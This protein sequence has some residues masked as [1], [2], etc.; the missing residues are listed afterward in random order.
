MSFYSRGS[1]FESHHWLSLWT[2]LICAVR[3]KTLWQDYTGCSFTFLTVVSVEV[4]RHQFIVGELVTDQ[5]IECCT[6]TSLTYLTWL[7]C[8]TS[9]EVAHHRA[10]RFPLQPLWLT[11]TCAHL[12]AWFAGVCCKVKTPS[13]GSARRVS[14]LS[15][16]NNNSDNHNNNNNN[17]NNNKYNNNSN[18][19]KSNNNNNNHNNNYN[20]VI[21]IIVMIVI[22]IGWSK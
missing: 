21:I 6:L 14:V 3:K 17:Y 20:H 19:N 11:C 7:V 15:T 10:V 8:W 22:V 16:L 13:T 12:L 18:N 4:F 9:V 1:R 5:G 2:H